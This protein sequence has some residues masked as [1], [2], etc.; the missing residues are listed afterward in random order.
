METRNDRP[1]APLRED[2]TAK[3]RVLA[4]SPLQ[5]LEGPSRDAILELARLEHLPKQ[6]SLSEQ[7]EPARALILL[8]SGRVTIERSSAGKGA[9][10]L[11]LGHRGPGDLVGEAAVGGGPA[12]ETATVIDAGV[13]LV[14]PLTGFR[15]LVAADASIREAMASALVNLYEGA[16][17]RLVSLL[18]RGVEGRLCEL[19]LGAAARWGQP[20]ASGEMI[21]APFTHAEI[22]RLIGSTRETVTLIFGKLRREGLVD[23]DH[24]RVVI[25]ERAS[26]ERRAAEQA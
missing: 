17:R 1:K 15:R 8:G 7:G 11:P 5:S 16:R 25:R 21:T 18:L 14:L 6:H 24:R 19:L 4:L 12:T 26:L 13:A 23:F 20:H 9:W 3:E 10:I 22:A 2:P